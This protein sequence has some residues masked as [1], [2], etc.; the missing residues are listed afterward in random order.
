MEPHDKAKTLAIA[1]LDVENPN[2]QVQASLPP[3]AED[4]R[5]EKR[6]GVVIGD[7]PV[8]VVGW[9]LRTLTLRSASLNPTWFQ[10]MIIAFSCGHVHVP[11]QHRSVNHWD[12]PSID[13][14]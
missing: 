3:S 12:L 6:V 8:Y 7:S 1:Q 14:K 4:H 5:T 9:R 13:D 10:L 11:R 2:S